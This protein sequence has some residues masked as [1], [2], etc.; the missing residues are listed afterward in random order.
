MRDYGQIQCGFWSSGDTQELSER[1]KLFACYLLTGP[2]SNGLGCYKLPDGYIN[3][4]FGWSPE[5]ISELFQELFRIGFCERCGSTWFVLMPNYLRWNPIANANIAKAR[6][7]EFELV[8]KKASIHA[9]LCA[10]MLT[11]G[12]HFGSV[13][14]TALKGFAERYGKQERRGEEPNRTFPNGEGGDTEVGSISV[15]CARGDGTHG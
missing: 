10:A 6:M 7:K 8:P 2:H 14:E 11:F 1:A 5:T 15:L 13:N 3:A 4:D 9:Q 12:N